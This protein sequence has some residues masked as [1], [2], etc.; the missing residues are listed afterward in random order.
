MSFDILQVGTIVP[1]NSGGLVRLGPTDTSSLT[2]SGKPVCGVEVTTVT[3]GFSLTDGT[4]TSDG[5]DISFIK[6]NNTVT[7]IIMSPLNFTFAINTATV[8]TP[9]GQSIIPAGLEPFGG[10]YITMSM[11]GYQGSG[12]LVSAYIAPLAGPASSEFVFTRPT[13]TGTWTA[14]NLMQV[15]QGTSFSWV[16]GT[17]PV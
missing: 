16:I 11:F 13:G 5:V 15:D 10:Q 3:G 14:G 8:S 6:Q 17:P 9:L 4:N 12:P 1:K 2:V 7:A